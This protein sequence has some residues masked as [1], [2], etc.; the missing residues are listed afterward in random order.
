PPFPTR[1][2][3]DLIRER[4]SLSHTLFANTMDH[5]S[6]LLLFGFDCDKAH[7]IAPG[8]VANG[9]GIVVI[10]LLALAIRYDELWCDETNIMTE[11]PQ[12]SAPEERRVGKE[13]RSRGWA[14]Q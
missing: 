7:V 13:G 12:L 4:G 11:A 8:S 2:S 9:F 5:E 6:R 1:R 10:V 14:E 3:S